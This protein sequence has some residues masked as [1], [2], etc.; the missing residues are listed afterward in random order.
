[1][2]QRSRL[3]A[4]GQVAHLR[5]LEKENGKLRRNLDTFEKQHANL[6]VLRE[7]NKALEKKVRGVD[8]LRHQAATL[9]S[10]LDAMKREK[11][12]W[13][14]TSDIVIVCFT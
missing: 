6:E 12:E 4:S 8:A 9:E 5:A 1:M 2:A 14:V 11:R 13:S 7:S 3:T 10:E